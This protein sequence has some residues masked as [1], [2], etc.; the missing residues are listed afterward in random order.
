MQQIARNLTDVED[1]FLNGKHYFLMDRDTK[2]CAAFLDILQDEGIK[3]LLLPLRS[4]DL[5]S[6][7]ERY[8]KSLKSEA[9]SRMISFGERSLR[10]TVT[11]FLAHYHAER[12]H[13]RLANGLS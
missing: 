11:A 9:L 3:P 5:N 10:R 6:Y 2:F 4:P 12:N 8:M 1:G 13:Q 7:I